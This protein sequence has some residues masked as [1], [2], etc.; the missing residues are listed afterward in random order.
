VPRRLVLPAQAQ[1]HAVLEAAADRKILRLR[2]ACFRDD[3][4][5]GVC[6]LIILGANV[7]A[8]A[9]DHDQDAEHQGSQYEGITCDATPP[10][11]PRN[12]APDCGNGSGSCD[13]ETEIVTNLRACI[14]G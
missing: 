12:K 1:T 13:P 9:S 11:D 8:L 4:C 3:V 2:D 14:S 5:R 10:N 7:A 6:I